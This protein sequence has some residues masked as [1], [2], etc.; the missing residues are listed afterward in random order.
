MKTWDSNEGYP[1]LTVQRNY[2]NETITLSQVS[3]ILKTG[4]EILL[5]AIKFF[6]KDIIMIKKSKATVFGTFLLI[7]CI[8]RVQ[9]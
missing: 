3:N 5:V 2:N 4:Q 8:N 1:L 9:I 7:T 6:R